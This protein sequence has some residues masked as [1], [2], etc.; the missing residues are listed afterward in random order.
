MVSKQ[1]AQLIAFQS[2]NHKHPVRA[3]RRK[4]LQSKQAGF[5]IAM[6]LCAILLLFVIGIGLSSMG[7]HRRV[8]AVQTCSGIAARSAADAGLT[9]ALFELNEKLKTKPWN[10]GSLPYATNESLPDSDAVFSY[11]VTGDRYNGYAIESVGKYGQVV[12]QVSCDLTLEGPFDT[13]IYGHDLISLKLGTT[14]NGY[15]YTKP[16]ECL[17]IGTNS[18]LPSR[19][20]AKSGVTIFGDVF[21]GPGGDPDVVIDSKH[22]AVIT[23]KTY[24]LDKVFEIPP[25]IVPQY[26][27]TLPSIGNIT[28][29]MTLTGPTRCESVSLMGKT[30]VIDGPVD[31]YCN[32][33]FTLDVLSS[34]VIVDP[35]INPDAHL[36]LY[37]GGN[38]TAKN[39][40]SVNNATKGPRK[41]KIYGLESCTN[42]QFYIDSVFYG[43][44]YA[45]NANVT[46]Q[47]SVEIYGAIIVR[48][49]TQQVSADF[50]YDASLKQGCVTDEMVTFVI[51]QWY[52]D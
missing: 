10:D 12:K 13:A 36:N 30:L 51:K 52:E 22:D 28:T 24:A 27:Q 46:L 44:I 48:Q 31:L 19:V 42:F 39:S 11:K 29:S 16:N 50:H 40:S 33:S 43:A 8:F 26:L 6:V 37:L 35:T 34:L 41:L 17:K 23:G 47:N 32:G 4:C 21:C 38:F 2:G 5:A 7:M 3:Q 45:P 15:N 1:I 20:I 18:I 14:I 25:V 49:L 9:K